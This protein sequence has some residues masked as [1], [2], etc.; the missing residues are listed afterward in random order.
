MVGV[1]KNLGVLTAEQVHEVM[2]ALSGERPVF[3]SEAD[4]QHAFAQM[5]EKRHPGLEVRLE[6]PYRAIGS[7]DPCSRTALD[8]RCRDRASGAV[9]A[10]EFKYRTRAWEGEVNGEKFRLREHS[11][12]DLGR[13]EFVHDL[14]RLEVWARAAGGTAFVVMLTNDDSYRRV[15]TSLGMTQDGAFRIHE[16]VT[17]AGELRWANTADSPHTRTLRGSSTVKWEDYADIT[18]YGVARSQ[19][20]VLSYAIASVDV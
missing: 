19:G 15:P 12:T 6:I 18:E 7:E 8:L 9:T 14:A 20:N 10:I 4:F 5:L 3:H 11:A 1:S 2:S 17:L 13:Q 16:G